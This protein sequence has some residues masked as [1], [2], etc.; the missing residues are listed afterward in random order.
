MLTTGKESGIR[1][2]SH[3]FQNSKILCFIAWE[4]FLKGGKLGNFFGHSL[5]SMSF[6]KSIT[7][8]QKHY[9][10][11]LKYSRKDNNIIKFHLQF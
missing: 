11:K 2:N 5:N 8:D 9:F 3:W 7:L 6:H 1:T 10:N 4:R